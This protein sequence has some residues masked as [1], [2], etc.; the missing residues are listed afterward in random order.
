MELLRGDGEIRR[1]LKRVGLG[2]VYLINLCDNVEKREEKTLRRLIISQFV[3]DVSLIVYRPA[4]SL[5]SVE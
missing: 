1:K 2:C 4:H 5:N 3:S